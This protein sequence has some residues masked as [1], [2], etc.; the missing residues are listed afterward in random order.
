LYSTL[1]GKQGEFPQ[2]TSKWLDFSLLQAQRLLESGL[3]K[4]SVQPLWWLSSSI[5]KYI[6]TLTP[7]SGF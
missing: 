6:R 4:E 2:C 7:A 3:G 1:T 5:V